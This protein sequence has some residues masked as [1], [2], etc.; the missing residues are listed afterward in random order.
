M[1]DRSPRLSDE[2]P[3]DWAEPAHQPEHDTVQSGLS[4]ESGA[5]GD[6]ADREHFHGNFDALSGKSPAGDDEHIPPDWV[7]QMET[8]AAERS[9]PTSTAR[10]TD[11]L[12]LFQARPIRSEQDSRDVWVNLDQPISFDAAISPHLQAAFDQI[13][14]SIEGLLDAV[15]PKGFQMGDERE[16]VMWSIV[17]AF[18]FHVKQKD[19]SIG[20]LSQQLLNLRKTESQRIRE[21]GRDPAALELEERTDQ[22]Q[23][24]STKRDVYE[25]IR[26]YTSD[27]YFHHANKVWEPRDTKKGSH[28]SKSEDV[29]KQIDG[30][31]FVRA[32]EKH[33]P[34]PEIPEGTLIA[35]A[36]GK[37]GPS[38]QTIIKTLDAQLKE[39]PDM[40]LAHG[41]A[42]GV[43]TTA[44]KWAKINDVPAIAFPP[45]FEKYK[46]KSIGTAIVRRDE[47]MLM[48][49]PDLVITFAAEGQRLPRLHT[50]AIERGITVETVTD[51]HLAA[52]ASIDASDKAHARTSEPI[53][54]T[55]APAAHGLHDNEA[56]YGS[57]H[58]ST[59]TL[60]HTPDI[61]PN[62]GFIQE[63]KREHQSDRY[64]A[65]FV[66]PAYEPADA[67]LAHPHEQA[68]AD[69]YLAEAADAHDRG[70]AELAISPS[71]AFR[72]L[73]D[74][75]L[76]EETRLSEDSVRYGDDDRN[77]LR[78]TL[79]ARVLNAFHSVTSG[80]GGASDMVDDQVR[81]GRRL[82]EE[83][84]QSE[85]DLNR[86][87][88]QLDKRD[89]ASESL[90]S[91]EQTRTELASFYHHE[92]GRYWTPPASE[93]VPN[94]RNLNS[95]SVDAL[96]LVER[97]QQERHQ[98]RLP[99]G[100]PIAVTALTQNADRY[101]VF[102]EMDR[103]LAKKP[104]MWIAHGNEQKGAIQHVSEWAASR[105]VDQV[106]FHP[107]YSE[108]PNRRIL[109]RDQAILDIKPIGVIEFRDG[110]NTTYLADKARENKIPVHSP[111]CTPR[112]E[113][114]KTD[115]RAQERSA[116]EHHARQRAAEHDTGMSW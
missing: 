109:K 111:D 86:Q 93:E 104:D 20:E 80:P 8:D 83:D 27:I 103:V 13:G 115:H 94:G 107:D 15:T 24:A 35:V 43:Q 59:R 100:V 17:H 4:E 11:D 18:D 22:L 73:I 53:S 31:E 33:L 38:H 56:A 96:N 102:K 76:P 116:T 69:A 92:T 44:A 19:K 7:R 98:A 90:H 47:Q 32:R 23:S 40:I 12:A 63:Q 21:Q 112:Q 50:G 105:K 41:G 6:S 71:Q 16:S 9:I 89:Y 85:I 3:D 49:R 5:Y 72:S 57:A 65:A 36:G 74:S 70:S 101:T 2:Y 95:A 14:E 55:A 51:R 58:G 10:I 67:R 29:T 88:E 1:S 61:S 52:A 78:V 60:P 66:D 91:L 113:A 37:I 25:A 30:R 114:S 62:A 46:D 48:A 77:P 45:D 26:D 28:V 75:A 81:Q 39:H 99:S 84:T 97:L 108:P 54:N 64:G 34:V 110:P 82:I 68:A 87:S 79:M 106:H 42:K